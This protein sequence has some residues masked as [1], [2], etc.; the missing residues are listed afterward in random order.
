M[1]CR[2]CRNEYT[3]PDI[4]EGVACFVCAACGDLYEVVNY[5]YQTK[6]QL[7][8]RIE[9]AFS[10]VVLGDGIGLFEAQALDDYES[11]DV[12]KRRRENDEKNDWKSIPHET[13]QHCYSSL[14]YFDPAGMKFHLPAYVVGSLKGKVDDV[15]F[16]LTHLDGYA[17]SK[18]DL[19]TES[20]RDILREYLIWCLTDDEY[21]I[22]R[23]DIERSL[24]EYWNNESNK[25]V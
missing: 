14:S 1:K 19:L 18:L 24:C 15:I 2:E 12:Q 21:G 7:I 4:I 9:S 8:E 3:E 11:D 22:Y 16:H 20:Q 17:K 10:G 23:V 13:L 25:L 6:E 5:K